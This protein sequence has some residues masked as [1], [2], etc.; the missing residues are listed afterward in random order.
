MKYEIKRIPV[1]HTYSS[2]DLYNPWTMS[3]TQTSIPS[4]FNEI[5][6]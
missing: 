6:K 1:S 5:W 2:Q 4:N 3:I